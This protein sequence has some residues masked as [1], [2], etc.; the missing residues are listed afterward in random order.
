GREPRRDESLGVLRARGAVRPADRGEHVRSRVIDGEQQGGAPPS[1]G[2][3]HSSS[4]LR[5][6]TTRP[7]PLRASSSSGTVAIASGAPAESAMVVGSGP[8]A[9]SP[10]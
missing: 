4:A 3:T 2:T 5:E 6:R 1:G 7:L 9:A 10:L 8:S